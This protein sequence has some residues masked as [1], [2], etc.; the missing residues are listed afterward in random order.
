MSQLSRLQ[1]CMALSKKGIVA[2]PTH[3]LPFYEIGYD[4]A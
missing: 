4:L 1:L 3:R 2:S